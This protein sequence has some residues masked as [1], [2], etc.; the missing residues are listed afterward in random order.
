MNARYFISA[1]FTLPRVNIHQSPNAF[2]PIALPR[3]PVDGLLKNSGIYSN[4][5]SY[6]YLDSR[7]TG[8]LA[9]QNDSGG[10]TVNRNKST[11]NTRLLT[12]CEKENPDSHRQLRR[13]SQ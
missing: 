10:R 13:G 5:C 6:S 2:A 1:Q 3:N 9:S 7:F 11:E 8:R 12:N 4:S